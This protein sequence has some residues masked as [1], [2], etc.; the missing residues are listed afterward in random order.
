MRTPA[1][2]PR[3]PH[4]KELRYHPMGFVVRYSSTAWRTPCG[5]QPCSGRPTHHRSC[6]V[7]KQMHRAREQDREA[8]PTSFALTPV[9]GSLL[10]TV[11]FIIVCPNPSLQPASISACRL[12][13]ESIA[14]QK[15][16]KSAVLTTVIVAGMTVSRTQS[17]AQ[18]RTP[19]RQTLLP[20]IPVFTHPLEMVSSQCS[21][22]PAMCMLQAFTTLPLRGATSRIVQDFLDSLR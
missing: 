4:H 14:A 8:Q 6:A 20:W 5:S 17:G 12:T 13:S 9:H 11:C 2:A 21:Q 1:Q 10:V 19:S 15:V 22:N 18:L 3:L 7:L 16:G